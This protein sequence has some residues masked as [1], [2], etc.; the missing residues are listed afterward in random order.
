MKLKKVTLVIPVY[1]SEKYIGRCLDS[2]INQT[3][4]DVDILVINDGSKDKSKEVVEEYQAKYNNIKL[5][6]Q[7]NMGVAK[8]RNKAIK[9]VETKYIMFIDNDDYIDEDYIETYINKI[10]ET[11][12]DIVMGGYKRVNIDKKILFKQKLLNTDWSKYIVLAPWA[13]I[14]NREFLL[15][16]NIKFLDYAIGEDV[17]FNLVAFA[18]KP[19]I[20]IIDNMGYNWFFNTKSV[21][22]TSQRGLSKEIDIRVLLD[23]ILTEYKEKDEFIQYYFVRYI[24]WYMLF[25]GMKSSSKNFIDYYN[26]CKTWLKENKITN[27]IS[28]FSYKLKG[29][30]FKNRIIV[31]IFLIVDKLHCIKLFSK[32]YCKGKDE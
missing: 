25:S 31:A 30:T 17:Y 32:I 1:N 28:P 19:K 3:Y 2:I 20:E 29:E 11:N 14:Y 15:N 21:S 6:N 16:N 18:K 10:E 7:D 5:I 9:I 13:K 8:T 26:M 24:V 27:T 23:K 4:N 12:T 22:N